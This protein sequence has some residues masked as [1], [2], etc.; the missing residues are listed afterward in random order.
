MQGFFGFS[1]FLW[2]LPIPSTKRHSFLRGNQ[3]SSIPRNKELMRIYRDVELVESL[4]SGIPRILRAYG[5]DCFKF[6]DNF[7][8]ITLPITA[9][10]GSKSA[11]S[12]QVSVQV[13]E[14]VKMLIRSIESKELSV[15]EIL[16]VYK[17]LYKQVYKS[18]WYLKK[19]T[20]QPAMLEGYVEMIYPD[21]PN[22]P[23]Q[24]YRLTAKGI[25]LKNSLTNKK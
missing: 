24:K 14:Q 7:I 11:P 21:K 10:E 5:E 1:N 18:K 23:K 16:E 15:D 19:H 25:S 2:R 13:S 17:L 20:I 6:T 9:H 8:R 4:G 3:L 12:E 22:H